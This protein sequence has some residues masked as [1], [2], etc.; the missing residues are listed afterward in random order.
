MKQAF[1]LNFTSIHAGAASLCIDLNIVL[2]LGYEHSL[3]DNM[4]NIG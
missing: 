3:N 4:H 1:F 2:E